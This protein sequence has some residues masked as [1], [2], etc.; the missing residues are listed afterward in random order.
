MG[1]SGPGNR[2]G[3]RCRWAGGGCPNPACWPA[4]AN[5]ER[6]QR[7]WRVRNR[8][9]GL[10]RPLTCAASTFTLPDGQRSDSRSERAAVERRLHKLRG[11][12]RSRTARRR[13]IPRPFAEL[14]ERGWT[15][16]KFAELVASPGSCRPVSSARRR[17]RSASRSAGWRPT[18][19]SASPCH[20]GSHRRH[21]AGRAPF[22]E[23]VDYSCCVSATRAAC[24]SKWA[25]TI[26]GA[27]TLSTDWLRIAVGRSRGLLCACR[28]AGVDADR[29]AAS[30]S[31]SQAAP[32]Q[33]RRILS[34]YG[35]SLGYY[36]Q[37]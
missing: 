30:F 22:C 13:F 6:C 28:T 25:T 12:A 15:L 29:D 16:R 4:L 14:G 7:D 35:P 32:R 37:R 18:R 27:R 21:G 9:E 33:A 20:P 11:R 24:S 17:T 34:R 19:R 10:P 36:P 8:T 31:N 2:R 3:A 23:R 26:R 1:P 5:V